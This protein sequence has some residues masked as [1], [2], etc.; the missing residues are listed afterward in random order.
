MDA[1]KAELE[2]LRVERKKCNSSFKAQSRE[3]RFQAFYSKTNS[4]RVGKYTPRYNQV[5]GRDKFPK[6]FIPPDNMGII[7]K[8]ELNIDSMSICPHAIRTI[9]DWASRKMMSPQAKVSDK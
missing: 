8:K 4:P 7:R 6:Y 2:F 5:D 9:E 1:E 3:D